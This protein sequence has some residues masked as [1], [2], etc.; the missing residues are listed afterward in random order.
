MHD[1]HALVVDDSKV[2]RLTML[3]KLEPL[4]I[5][6]DMVESGQ[7][8]LDFLERGRPDLIFMD[9]M[10]PDLDGFEVTR[11]IKA[12]PETRD[13]PVFI[14]SGNDEA[15]FV[16]EAREAG[17]LDAIAKPPTTEALERLL[18]SLPAPA[19]G[20][21]GRAVTPEPAAAPAPVAVEVHPGLSLEQ[22]Q[23]LLADLADGLR[24]EFE[25]R[26][27][28]V[29][30]AA[31]SPRQQGVELAALSARVAALDVVA[32]RP[33]PDVEGLRSELARGLEAGLSGLAVRVEETDQR[34][35]A[36]N[37]AL[38]ARAEEATQP[39]REE[40]AALHRRLHDLGGD[41]GGDL[42]RL[43]NELGLLAGDMAARLASLE[44]REEPVSRAVAGEGDSETSV[45]LV[46][47]SELEAL[48]ERLSDTRLRQLVA[49]SLAG[50]ATPRPLAEVARLEAAL[51]RLKT[52]TLAG[53]VVLL[54]LVGLAIFL[55]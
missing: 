17:A 48:N 15:A 32:A 42:G 9:H 21:A 24:S 36:L 46:L 55:A 14:V 45:Y 7:E 18:A 28:A 43:Q 49:E 50:E 54:G 53:G 35:E 29:Q 4:G 22:V 11:R 20:A 52:L 26:L 31:E 33:Q 2:G 3:K 5:R 16:L 34:L 44:R 30:A 13:I 47:Q 1:L 10:M 25:A 39:V 12:S 37:R 6:V 23:A 38:P 19:T 41:L 51:K 8:A 27:A 40:V